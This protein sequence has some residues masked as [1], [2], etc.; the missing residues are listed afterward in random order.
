MKYIYSQFKIYI[1]E[2]DKLDK[3][4][5]QEKITEE[6]YYNIEYA[7]HLPPPLG[8]KTTKI[9]FDGNMKMHVEHKQ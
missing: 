1:D 8:T 4:A 5:K 6:K 2:L 9:T 7:L 3:S